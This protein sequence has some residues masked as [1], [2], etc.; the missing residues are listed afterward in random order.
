MDKQWST[1]VQSRVNNG[2]KFRHN[3]EL[4]QIPHSN[5]TE[6]TPDEA[7]DGPQEDEV[8]RSMVRLLMWQPVVMSYINTSTNTIVEYRNLSR[9]GGEF[10]KLGWQSRGEQTKDSCWHST[11]NF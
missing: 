5:T 8:S 9:H 4:L 3:T 10:L 2:Y 1:M 11:S 6:W 7:L